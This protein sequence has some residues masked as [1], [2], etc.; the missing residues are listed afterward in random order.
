LYLQRLPSLPVVTI[1]FER[2]NYKYASGVA[3]LGLWC[4]HTC[5]C[6]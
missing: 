5:R 2:L 3:E 1:C 4:Q 6:M